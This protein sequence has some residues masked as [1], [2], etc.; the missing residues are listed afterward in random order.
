MLP[1][2][3][4]ILKFQDAEYWRQIK[5]AWRSNRNSDQLEEISTRNIICE[6]PGWGV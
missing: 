4:I 5:K 2:D 3:L 1:L 6:N